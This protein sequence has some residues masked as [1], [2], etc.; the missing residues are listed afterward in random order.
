MEKL[1][2]I[3]IPSYNSASFL[4]ETV[5]TFV[6]ITDS[7]RHMVEVIIVNDGSTDNTLEVAN[8]LATQYPDIVRVID[9][10]NGGHGSTINA[11]IKSALGKYFKIVDGDDY[12]DSAEFERLILFLQNS[13]VDQVITPFVKDYFNEEK[14][15]IIDFENVESGKEYTYDE[16]LS[17]VGR[18]PDMHA[19]V[20]R[21]EL[22]RENNIQ[23]SEHCFYVDMQYNVF[24]M[25]LINK[26][27]YFDT[28]IYQYQLGD[29]NQSVSL[30]NYFKNTKMHQH[31]I[32]S[33]INYQAT[34]SDKLSNIQLQLLNKLISALIS[35]QINIFL[36]DSNI[37]KSQKQYEDYMEKIKNKHPFSYNNP[38]G[39]KAKIL[40]HF[41]FM[42]FLMAK[43]YQIQ[44]KS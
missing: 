19:V 16:F 35:I 43:L 22:L 34:N 11:G 3:V 28:P 29:E 42:Y 44:T 20:N 9:K 21:T 18:I 33:L 5:P 40:K 4:P 12:V 1:I 15:E 31:V 8:E 13:D 17:L 14:K 7:V 27:A 23:L 25:H 39:K 6:N 37:R 36:Y 41:P 30:Q 24:P 26:V 38:D 2:S 10:E 32:D